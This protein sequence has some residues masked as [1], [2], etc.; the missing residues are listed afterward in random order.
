[1]LSPF[2]RTRQALKFK[3]GSPYF[4]QKM[5]LSQHYI[6]ELDKYIEFSSDMSYNI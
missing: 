5:R 1:M 4:M 3:L 2:Y 6:R